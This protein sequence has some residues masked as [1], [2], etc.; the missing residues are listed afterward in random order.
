MLSGH[1]LVIGLEELQYNQVYA[2]CIP[3]AAAQYPLPDLSNR[4]P[5]N[6]ICA[7]DPFNLTVSLPICDSQQLWHLYVPVC[8]HQLQLL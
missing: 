5:D 4:H 3:D 8:T 2:S 7:A 6:T 1:P